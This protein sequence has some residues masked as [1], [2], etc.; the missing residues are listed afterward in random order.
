[1]VIF[2]HIA[3]FTRF[4]AANAHIAFFM[5]FSHRFLSFSINCPHAK[6]QAAGNDSRRDHMDCLSGRSIGI[7][8]AW[9]TM[10]V[11]QSSISNLAAWHYGPVGLVLLIFAI[12][13]QLKIQWISCHMPQHWSMRNQKNVPRR[14]GPS[15]QHHHGSFF[16]SSWASLTPGIPANWPTPNGWIKLRPPTT[17]PGDFIENNKFLLKR[18][19]AQQT[20]QYQWQWYSNAQCHQPTTL[21]LDLTC[22]MS[23]SSGAIRLVCFF[24]FSSW[25]PSATDPPPMRGSNRT[26]AP[27]NKTQET[28]LKKNLDSL[29]PSLKKKRW[30]QKKHS[31][32]AN[33]IM[34]FNIINQQ[35]CDV[36]VFRQGPLGAFLLVL[37]SQPTGPPPMRG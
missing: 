7:H 15:D 4:G 5:P 16:F 20:K 36:L 14:T 29:N 32:D 22:V 8:L 11:W 1:M 30:T 25:N 2:L 6:L 34:I 24:S 37:E 3:F 13:V 27:N 12:H 23:F 33:E 31:I 9:T 10:K 26:V 18:W 21:D 17:K 28:Q 19:E 35:L